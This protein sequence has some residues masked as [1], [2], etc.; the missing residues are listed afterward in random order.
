MSQVN[1][2]PAVRKEAKL[3]RTQIR[4]CIAGCFAYGLLA[5]LC[6]AAALCAWGGQDPSVS[7]QLLTT[8]QEIHRTDQALSHERSRLAATR[9]V[10]DTA[11][12]IVER[13]DWS[14]LLALLAS[15]SEKQ[16]I[17]RNCQLKPA[18]AA[19]SENKAAGAAFVFT[20]IGLARSAADA[21]DYAIRLQNSHM[22]DRVTL[23]DTRREPFLDSEASAFRIECELGDVPA[24]QAGEAGKENR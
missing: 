15:E 11:R 3:R 18:E 14:D 10:L 6:S 1:L 22:F 24:H 2:I 5:A 20:A 13:P 23:L 9:N 8:Q 12:T 19:V 16:V 21:Q 17:L 4:R 7:Q